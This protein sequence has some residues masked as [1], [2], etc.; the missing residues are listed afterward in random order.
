MITHKARILAVYRGQTVDRLPYVPRIDLW[1]LA[2]AAS[3]TIPRQHLGRTQNEISRAEGWPLHHK[4]AYNLMGENMHD[5]LLHRGIGIY[6]TRECLVDFVMPKDC[7][8][9]MRRDGDCMQVEYATP[10]GD[11]S[12]TVQYTEAMQRLGISIPHVSEHLIKTP[13][14]YG[15]AGWLYEHMDVVPAFERFERWSRDEMREDGVPVAVGFFG[16]SP[17]QQVQR[18]LIDATQFFF[19][20]KDHYAQ[21]RGLCER[22]EPLFDKILRI[23]AASPAEVAQWGTNF[24]DML[25]YPPYFERE[26][27]PWVRKASE[28]LGAAGKRVMC[29]TDGENRGLMDLIRDCGLHIAESICPAPM[30]NVGIAEYYARWSPHLTLMG[31]VPSTMLLPET[32][33]A[34]FEACLDELFRAVAPGQRMVIAVADQVPPKA[35]F[36]RLQRIGERVEREGRLPLQAGSFRPAAATAAGAS[37]PRER[38][39]SMRDESLFAKVRQDVLDG[40]NA[41]IETDVMALVKQGIPAAEILD[42]GLIAAMDVIGKQFTSGEAFIPEVLLSARAMNRAVEALGPHLASQGE[43]QRGKVLIGTVAGDMHDIGKNMVVTMLKGV[44]FEVKDLGINVP[45]ETFVKEVSE[46]RPDILGLSALLTT[47]MTEMR[48]VIQVLDEHELRRHCKVI[49]GGAPV[50]EPFAHEIGAD[51]WAADAVAAVAL[52]KQLI[53]PEH[54]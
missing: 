20:Y 41:G 6:R 12:C 37:A 17:M 42:R 34:Q 13:A 15:P 39:T 11:L 19:H 25:T 26:I 7:E 35:V 21:L 44:G 4:Y 50:S 3:G 52:A 30:T 49:V 16:A 22:M 1:Y 40:N 32:S 10:V 29:H 5:A 53:S 33:E 28:V 2:N 14:D 51:G 48:S 38:T 43:G 18:D 8:I 9:R 46:Y 23:T 24:D 45:R 54:R 36:S 27:L 31:G 47:T